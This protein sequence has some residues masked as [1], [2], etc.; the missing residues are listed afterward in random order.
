M[1]WEAGWFRSSREPPCEPHTKLLA[2]AQLALALGGWLDWSLQLILFRRTYQYILLIE[3][4]VVRVG[5][6][7]YALQQ[8]CFDT[9]LCIFL[10]RSLK[11]F[12][13]A[14]HQAQIIMLLLGV[15]R[16]CAAACHRPYAYL[17]LLPALPI[18]QLS[19]R[20]WFKLQR[21]ETNAC[22]ARVQ[23]ILGFGFDADLK[24]TSPL[25]APAWLCLTCIFD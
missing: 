17:G 11:D 15:I 9:T 4:G 13:A 1:W 21:H 22:Q 24:G 8:P 5:A 3:E 6:A 7:C 12:T 14:W 20:C 10:P 25:H 2:L 16:A 18:V 19:R 23:G